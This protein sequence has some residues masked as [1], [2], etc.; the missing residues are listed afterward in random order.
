MLDKFGLAT[1]LW[2]IIGAF[3][4][5]ISVSFVLVHRLF[6]FVFII[7]HMLN[8]QVIHSPYF[9][10]KG[11][12]ILIK[13]LR[14]PLLSPKRLKLMFHLSWRIDHMLILVLLILFSFPCLRMLSPIAS[15]FS[16]AIWPRTVHF[17]CLVSG[18][19]FISHV[20]LNFLLLLYLKKTWGHRQGNIIA[21][22]NISEECRL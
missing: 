5:C 9:W 14:R 15:L 20:S 22:K 11:K 13:D 2:E 6:I 16:L 10:L 4:P 21:L 8:V 3:L 12:K 19:E 17:F 7:Y 1:M 18:R